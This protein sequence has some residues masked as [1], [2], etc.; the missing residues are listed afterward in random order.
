MVMLRK[1]ALA[2]E[3]NKEAEEEPVQ[4]K[5]GKVV[6]LALS[7][8][9]T[10]HA[11]FNAKADKDVVETGRA[12][13]IHPGPDTH[14]VDP[15][16]ADDAASDRLS[17]I[18]SMYNEK[19][20]SVKLR[21]EDMNTVDGRNTRAK[22]HAE[23]IQVDSDDGYQLGSIAQSPTH[24]R[25]DHGFASSS[26]ALARTDNQRKDRALELPSIVSPDKKQIRFD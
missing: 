12:V 6:P 14:D 4:N 3:A 26:L 9:E 7:S 13:Q 25:A 20:R 5:K 18:M 23:T 11:H 2:V 8:V 15:K 24:S 19:V 1:R 10:V 21:N 22:H 17:M 16:R